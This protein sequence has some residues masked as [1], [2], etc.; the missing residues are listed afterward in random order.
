VV[1]CCLELVLFGVPLESLPLN[2]KKGVP[3]IISKCVSFLKRKGNLFPGNHGNAQKRG[4][5]NV[6][7]EL[8]QRA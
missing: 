6:S 2:K 5:V 7:T 8:H 4:T 1:T 3:R